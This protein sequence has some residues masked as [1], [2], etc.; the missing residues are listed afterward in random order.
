[1]DVLSWV[2]LAEGEAAAPQGGSGLES[3]MAMAPILFMVMIFYLL[4]IRPQQR[5][6]AK[7]QA[8]L[9]QLKKDD[10][11]VTIGGLIG[12]VANMSD[13]GKEITLKV[14]DNMRIRVLRSAVQSRVSPRAELE[15]PRA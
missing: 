11:V 14:A 2:L 8:E 9:S 13:D 12:T 10:E 15:K 6:Q 4:I 7:R 5:E 1:M 3:L